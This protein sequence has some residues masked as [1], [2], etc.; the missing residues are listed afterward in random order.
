M[1]VQEITRMSRARLFA[2][3]DAFE[4]DMRALIDRYIL[5]H[6]AEETS[7][8][9]EYA[10]AAE[11]R[12]KDAADGN[13][14]SI[15]AYLDLRPAYDVLNRHRKDLPQDL[16]TEIRENTIQ[17]DR[18][19]PIR[20]RVM[21]GRP[22]RTEDPEIAFSAI[23][24]FTTRF[25][26][27]TRDIEL[28]MRSDELWEPAPKNLPLPSERVLHNLPYADY[29]ETGL[30]GRESQVTE[31]AEMLRRRRN[32][33]ITLTGEGGVG[34]TALA[35]ELG[36]LMVD[37]P[38][39]PFDCVIWSSL[40]S[41]R[42]TA[43]GVV[44]IADAVDGIAAVTREVGRAFDRDFDGSTRELADSLEG[45]DALIIIDNLESV[46]GD[47]VL[48]LYDAMPSC[49]SFLFT[50]RIGIGEVERRYRLGPLDAK[51]AVLL[52]RKFA[53]ARGQAAI[54][55]LSPQTIV[56]VVERLRFSPLAIRWFVLSVEAGADPL[57]T[58]RNQRELLSFCVQNVFERLTPNAKDLLTVIRVLDRAA[59]LDELSL[60]A[61][62]NID[63][64]RGAAQE[65]SRGSLITYES[66]AE[67]GLASKIGPSLAVKAFLPR[68][69]MKGERLAALLQREADFRMSAERRRESAAQRTLAPWVVN[70]RGPEDEP[71][72]YLLHQ[73]LNASKARRYAHAMELVAKARELNPDYYEVDR[74]EAFIAS[75]RGHA[76]RAVDLYRSALENCTDDH[77][78]A[79]VSH[80]FA[81]HLA[82]QMHDLPLAIG[83]ARRTHEY[84]Q[85][86]ETAVA[87]GNLLVWDRHFQ[88]GQELIEQALDEAEGKARLIAVTAMVESWRRW[89]EHLASEHRIDDAFEHART[90]FML[91]VRELK[92]FSDRRLATAVAEALNAGFRYIAVPGAPLAERSRELRQMMDLAEK[93]RRTLE[94]ATCWPRL[95]SAAGQVARISGLDPHLREQVF[96]FIRIA[97]ER[98]DSVPLDNDLPLVGTLHSWLSTFGFIEHSKFSG[99]VFFHRSDIIDAPADLRAGLIV[100]FF[101]DDAGD[102][103]RAKDVRVRGGNHA[104][105][106][107]D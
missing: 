96:R 70:A 28:R 40:K 107:D 65:L 60:L 9:A 103:P 32:R 92:G 47:E 71:A 67:G 90:G 57:T 89:S 48:R 45:L 72:A 12:A 105:T 52:L 95:I 39:T 46:T 34:K 85:S 14:T 73:A 61:D 83:Y 22:L 38:Q 79:V 58:V 21:H 69:S 25:W 94:L 68:E 76:H 23:S 77:S 104:D 20:N 36:Y 101:V 24:A 81:G 100:E 91:G 84:F 1:S 31:L 35:L 86:S 6:Q 44:Q 19:V 54:A 37:D 33:V 80:F 102:R 56:S 63:D 30:I 15:A 5:D 42:L 98:P 59:P 106:S 3:I 13:S 53:R 41:E 97:A 27:T 55:N 16:G 11:R 18:L 51:D 8:G 66:D 88:E 26:R 10:K 64:L 50:S 29:D 2:L 4:S 74:T 78:L 93:E 7:L 62:L 17:I 49:V 43:A 75:A 87:L 82:R 99:N